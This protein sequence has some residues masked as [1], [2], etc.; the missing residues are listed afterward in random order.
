MDGSIVWRHV[1]GGGSHLQIQVCHPAGVQVLEGLQGLLDEEGHLLLQK[2]IMG[3]QV[4]KET[5]SFQATDRKHNVR[6][7]QP[8]PGL[9]YGEVGSSGLDQGEEGVHWFGPG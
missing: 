1:G 7:A 8:N 3:G 9:G 2:S 4:V 5:A 6:S